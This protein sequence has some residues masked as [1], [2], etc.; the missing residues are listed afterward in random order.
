MKQLFILAL[1]ICSALVSKAQSTWSTNV[2]SGGTALVFNYPV[3]ISRV[4]VSGGA[5][6]TTA[7]LYDNSTASLTYTNAAYTTSTTYTTN[8]TSITTNILGQLNTNV[9]SGLVTS[10]VSVSANTNNLPVFLSVSA[11]ANQSASVVGPYNTV[12]GLVIDYSTNA[13]VTVVYRRLN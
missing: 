4:T 1:L 9:Y 11:G 3:S 13:S 6:A 8:I 10:S 12:R 7:N 5:V 2:T